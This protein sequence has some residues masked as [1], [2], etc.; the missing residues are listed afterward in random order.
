MSDDAPVLPRVH[1]GRL[2]REPTVPTSIK[3]PQSVHTAFAIASV[4]SDISIHA[5][6]VRALRAYLPRLPR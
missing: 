3:I 4:R 5:L 2:R 6:L 1:R